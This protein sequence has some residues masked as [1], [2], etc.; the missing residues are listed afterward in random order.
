MLAGALSIAGVN[1]ASAQDMY[2][3]E[4]RAFGFNF[5]PVG[6]A[7]ANG[8]ILSI[9]ANA[10]L[11]ALLGT[12]Y[13]GNGT[14]TFGLPNL[15]SR[16]PYGSGQGPGLPN[17]PL[18]AL[19]GTPTVTLL[20]QNL[21][22]H[23][24]QLFG[25]SGLNS[26]GSNSPAGALLPSYAAAGDKFYSATGA[27]N[28]RP[29]AANAIGLTGSGIPINTQSPGLALTWCIATSGIFPSRP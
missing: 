10:A 20:T 16:A 7:S 26:A 3:G 8:A 19:F 1:L 18:G 14:S 23:T 9:S 13:G 6:W 12:T 5:C 17:Y 15:Q 24:H 25:T 29:M 22:P 4:L 2:L 27:P 21:P 11:F 28:D